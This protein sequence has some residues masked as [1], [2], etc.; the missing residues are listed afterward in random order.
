MRMT[1]SKVGF[2]SPHAGEIPHLASCI[3]LESFSA[4]ACLCSALL[5]LPEA[6]LGVVTEYPWLGLLELG[7]LGLLELLLE[8]LLGSLL[9]ERLLERLLLEFGP[10]V[11]GLHCIGMFMVI[12][13]VWFGK[14][15]SLIDSG[16]RGWLLVL[17]FASLP[18]AC[19]GLP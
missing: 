16:H 2:F 13:T 9:L 1:A 11:S 5:P 19:C 10:V 4:S 17:Q 18:V 7:L 14:K 8:R 15:V 6:W 12:G 3:L